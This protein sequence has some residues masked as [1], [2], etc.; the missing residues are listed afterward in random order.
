MKRLFYIGILGLILFEI[1]NVYFIMPMPGSQRMRSIDLAYFFYTW[2]WII[3]GMFGL[4]VILGFAKVY[5]ASKWIACGGI[6]LLLITWYVVNF[7]M[8]ADTMFYQPTTLIL[9]N[10]REN[11]IAKD[12][13]IVG[14][15]INGVAKA[16]PIQLIA[17][18]HQVL[19]SIGGTPV[20]VTYCSVCRTGRVF[21]PLVKG[22]YE[23]FRLVGMDH[24]NA[25]FEDFTTKSWWR[26]ANGEAVTGTLKGQ[27]LP[28][29]L[30]QQVSLDKWLS[31]HPN[32][33]IMQPDPKF[34][35][36]Y[37]NLDKYE[38]GKGKSDLTRTD[39]LS[40]KDKSWIV[41]IA[42]DRDSKAFDWNR[43]KKE[44]VINDEIGHKPVAIVL[45]TDNKS[46]FAFERPEGKDL[47]SMKNDTLI[48]QNIR[49]SLEGKAIDNT[50]NAPKLT[51]VKVYQEFWHS[52]QSFHPGTRR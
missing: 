16:Y 27:L 1:L 13:L 26:Q 52:W 4:L 7:R 35:E 23:K 38:T 44:K 22:K 51:K 5:D 32:S 33:L 34:E 50:E 17:Y 8:S 14:V 29:V 45:S 18:H 2:R 36:K 48:F 21:E 43:L 47:L 41:G 49:Y 42:I 20:M 28:E 11:K 3:R 31:L 10:A 25:M 19:D 39:S 9:K 40:W 15:E 37:K 24:F 30:S 6:T 12:R 46:F